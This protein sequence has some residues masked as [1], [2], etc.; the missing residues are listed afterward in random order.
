VDAS[1]NIIVAGSLS[2][3]LPFGSPAETIASVGQVDA[4][5]VKL[6]VNGTAFSAIWTDSFGR[7]SKHAQ[8]K[9]VATSSN[10]DVY[11]AGLFDGSMGA[12]NLTSFSPNNADGF[13]ARLNGQTGGVLCAQVYGDAATVQEADYITVARAASGPLTDAVSVG[14]VFSSTIS[15]GATRLSVPLTVTAFFVAGL[16]P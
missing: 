2:G 15:F 16:S 6:T 1:N 14:G 10:G 7:P 5:V 11:L 12:M 3:S 9:S 8:A 4:F 13:V